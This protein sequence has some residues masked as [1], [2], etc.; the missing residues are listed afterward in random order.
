MYDEYEY[1][2][3]RDNLFER[4]KYEFE[5]AFRAIERELELNAYDGQ[6]EARELQVRQEEPQQEDGFSRS[7][8]TTDTYELLHEL[9]LHSSGLQAT[10]V[11]RRCGK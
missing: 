10:R 9:L 3:D 1:T 5:Q 7:S 11:Q 2:F 4:N 6:K 8:K